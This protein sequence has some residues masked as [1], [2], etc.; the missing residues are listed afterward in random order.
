MSL[1][2]N[3]FYQSLVDTK[4]QPPLFPQVLPPRDPPANS[5]LP[6]DSTH[7]GE[8]MKLSRDIGSLTAKLDALTTENA[9][10]KQENAQLKQQLAA[11]NKQTVVATAAAPPTAAAPVVV[12]QNKTTLTFAQIAA[13]TT[14]SL[15][16]PVAPMRLPDA[17]VQTPALANK[18]S[19]AD[20]TKNLS[21]PSNGNIGPVVLSTKTPAVPKKLINCGISRADV[22]AIL[23]AL[24]GVV[25]EQLFAQVMDAL[26]ASDETLKNCK[27]AVRAAITAVLTAIVTYPIIL[28]EVRGDG[29]RDATVLNTKINTALKP[30]KFMLYKTIFGEEFSESIRKNLLGYDNR[31]VTGENASKDEFVRTRGKDMKRFAK[32]FMRA[33]TTYKDVS[34]HYEINLLPFNVVL[35]LMY[36]NMR[37]HINAK[38]TSR[39]TQIVLFQPSVIY[40]FFVFVGD[41]KHIK[42]ITMSRGKSMSPYLFTLY[43]YGYWNIIAKIPAVCRNLSD[44]EYE[45]LEETDLGTSWAYYMSTGK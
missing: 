6:R 32:S 7:V 10:L 36:L 37:D 12:T 26:N 25:D 11:S 31:R 35:T 22:V 38:S 19:S 27:P 5:P 1:L 44:E 29:Y 21:P 15:S 30:E 16:S 43:S 2:K 42:A 3:L 33:R 41:A 8:L 34:S 13:A 9:A 39:E 23:H 45:Y 4:L 24:R 14:T 18:T 17:T 28:D 20:E 40:T